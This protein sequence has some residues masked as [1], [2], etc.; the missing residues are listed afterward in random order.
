MAADGRY[1]GPSRHF[2]GRAGV[3]RADCACAGWIAQAFAAGR[4]RGISSII[5]S[6]ADSARVALI[7]HDREWIERISLAAFAARAQ[8]HV[9]PGLR[10]TTAE[11]SAAH[12]SLPHAAAG[13]LGRLPR[14]IEGQT[15]SGGGRP[16]LTQETYAHRGPFRAGVI[17]DADVE[18]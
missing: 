16:A 14:R 5:A 8:P 1:S 4:C 18:S 9:L 11:F 7:R 12:G 2:R 17:R 15:R 3:A 13:A 6:R 10:E